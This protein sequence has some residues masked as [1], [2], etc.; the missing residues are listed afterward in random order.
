MRS[1]IY[2]RVRE[3]QSRDRGIPLSACRSGNASVR[4][5]AREPEQ[6]FAKAGRLI[7]A[8]F[9]HLSFARS[10]PLKIQ[11][12][13][14]RAKI[15]NYAHYKTLFRAVTLLQVGV[16]NQGVGRKATLPTRQEPLCL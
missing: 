12:H 8:R 16:S 15:L 9:S 6:S 10:N 2:R 4:I 3:I 11:E 1:P 7:D 14:G 5:P 13:G